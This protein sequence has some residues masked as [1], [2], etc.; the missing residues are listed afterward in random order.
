MT[1]AGETPAKTLWNQCVSNWNVQADTLLWHTASRRLDTQGAGR[2]GF[3]GLDSVL[4]AAWLA[5]MWQL[6]PTPVGLPNPWSGD[7]Q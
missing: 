1:T 6:Q 3:A 4:A 5:R 2:E 7:D